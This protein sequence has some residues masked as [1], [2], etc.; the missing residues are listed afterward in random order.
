M[1]RDGPGIFRR[2][3]GIADMQVRNTG[4]GH[5]IPDPGL[6]HFHPVQAVK[7]VQLADLHPAQFVRVMMVDYHTLLVYPEGPVVNFSDPDTPHVLVIVNG[8]DEH[9]GIR[10]RIPFGGRDIV[11]N[12]L[13]Q[14]L[15]A[16]RLIFHPLF[17]KPLPGRGKYKG[18]VQLFVR[19]VQIHKKLQ[20]LVYNLVRP[21]LRAVNLVDAHN[22]RQ[23]QFQ[24]FP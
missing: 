22:R 15:H 3:D 12:R 4:H 20:P 11:Y 1:E 17:G 14:R 10:V 21:G 16:F 19:S 7:L 5:D 2:T 8:A 23:I 18:A 24:G 13:K 6:M 9:L